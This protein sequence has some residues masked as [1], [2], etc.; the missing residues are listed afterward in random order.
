MKTFK[1]WMT[2]RV[3]TKTGVV[4][5][6]DTHVE[7]SGGKLDPTEVDPETGLVTVYTE[8]GGPMGS[9]IYLNVH[10]DDLEDF[11]P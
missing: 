3:T 7:V 10:P 9:P 4:L 8:G 5:K 6:L 2:L 1:E 11:D